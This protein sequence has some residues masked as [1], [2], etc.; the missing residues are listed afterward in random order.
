MEFI[1]SDLA[2]LIMTAVI[3]IPLVIALLRV[4]GMP[5]LVGLMF[6]AGYSFYELI[7]LWRDSTPLSMVMLLIVI[8]GLICITFICYG[9]GGFH[10]G[11]VMFITIWATDTLAYIFGRLIGGPKI[12]PSV[13]PKKTWAG[14][15]GA[16]IGPTLVFLYFYPSHVL[17]AILFGVLFGA[18]AQT[19]DFVQSALKRK[20][21][22]KDSGNL[23]PGHGG[24][25]DR[26]D[27]LLLAA[28]ILIV[29]FQMIKTGIL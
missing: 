1:R 8:T 16:L 18:L 28:P 9:K 27:G 2:K 25:L 7:K 11:M 22:V 26:I 19:G 15:V 24:L 29:F 23:L 5:L 20:A 14:L 21:N 4:N 13:S 10:Q 12:L 6:M 3:L 17:G